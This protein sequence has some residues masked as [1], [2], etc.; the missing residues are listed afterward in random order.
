[1]SLS[2][3][4]TSSQHDQKSKMCLVSHCSIIS[5]LLTVIEE[6]HVTRSFTI[7]VIIGGK[8]EKS[9]TDL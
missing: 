7:N 6:R 2:I 3:L 5:E 1:M 9:I 4:N 8:S